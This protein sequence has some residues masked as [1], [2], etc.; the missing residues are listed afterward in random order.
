ME[1]IKGQLG[2]THIGNSN[3][4]TKTK[5]SI[6]IYK[7]SGLEPIYRMN[8]RIHLGY[9]E[10]ID[11]VSDEAATK[12]ITV[13]DGVMVGGTDAEA[14]IKKMVEAASEIFFQSKD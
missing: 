4:S 11:C 7:G 13:I 6:L 5:D 3:V 1:L 8:N 9:N 2:I 12:L 10:H 14:A